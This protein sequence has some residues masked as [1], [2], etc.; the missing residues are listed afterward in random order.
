MLWWESQIYTIES[1]FLLDNPHTFQA[2]FQQD[3]WSTPVP[4]EC[5]LWA[6]SGRLSVILRTGGF[7]PVSGHNISQNLNDST[8]GI[9]SLLPFVKTG[10]RGSI[11]A[12]HQTATGR[13][14]YRIYWITGSKNTYT[15][16]GDRKL[17]ETAASQAR[18]EESRLRKP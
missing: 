8:S 6:I 7:M 16:S 15:K 9:Y 17:L 2:G 4:S 10:R 1:G 18:N 14:T 11:A 5:L 13:F 12:A 3:G